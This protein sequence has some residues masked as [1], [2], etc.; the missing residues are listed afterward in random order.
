M[1]KKGLT[2][3]EAAELILRETEGPL[4]AAELVTEIRKR[5]LIKITGKT[6]PKTMNARI[7]VDIKVKGERSHF[8]RVDKGKYTLR[9]LPGEEYKAKPHGK[10]LSAKDKVLVFPTSK[11]DEIGHFHGIRTD[12]EKYEKEL[13]NPETSFFINRLTAEADNNYQYKQIVSYVIIT[14]RNKLLRFTR[15]V[16]TNIGQYL[17]GEYS[18]GFGGHVEETPDWQLPLFTADCGYANSVRRELLQEINIDI[19]ALSKFNFKII[20]VLN[21]DSTALGRRHFAFVHLLELYELPTE[22]AEYFKKGEKSINDPKL[23]DIPDTSKEFEGYEYWSKIC[24]QTF[25]GNQLSFGCSV[26][27]KH[28]FSLR[29]QNE[30][31]LIVGYIGSGKTEAC[32]LLEHEFGYTL[33]PCS[34]IMQHEIGCPPINE[35]GR[36]ALQQIGLNFVTKENGHERLSHAIAKRINQNPTKKYI[37]DGLRYPQTYSVLKKMLGRDISVLY[38]ESTIDSLYKYFSRRENK[39]KNNGM[40]QP[41]FSEF[42]SIVYHPVEREIE[43]FYPIADITVYNH[44]SK[45]AYLNALREYFL[46]ELE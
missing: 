19:Q 44:G 16:I 27:P 33:L 37:L 25:F 13:L 15:G 12:F 21:D 42:L 2:Y 18:I 9:E 23:V 39:K 26:N 45:D 36:H 4:S 8:K 29:K 31:I 3:L 6:P 34:K 14:Y 35:I 30:I 10:R 11:L 28:N 41:T 1:A 46:K 20:G 17:H 43:R 7:S 5:R 32:K 40:Q 38:V 22:E 24:L